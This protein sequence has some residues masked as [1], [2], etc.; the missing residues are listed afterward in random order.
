MSFLSFLGIWV[1]WVSFFCEMGTKVPTTEDPQVT[2]RC[3]SLRGR[4]PKPPQLWA[5]VGEWGLLSVSSP[6]TAFARGMSHTTH[7][8]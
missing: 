5:G 4:C 6:R 2:V 8:A 1:A 7:T 3:L